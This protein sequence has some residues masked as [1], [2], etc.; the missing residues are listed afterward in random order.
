[1]IGSPEHF[2]QL[3]KSLARKL[4]IAA[5][6]SGLQVLRNDRGWRENEISIDYI[7]MVT[8]DHSYSGEGG[9]FAIK[10]KESKFREKV[11]PG[12]LVQ[13]IFTNKDEISQ[14][15]TETGTTDLRGIFDFNLFEGSQGITLDGVSYTIRISGQNIDT[16]ISL[17]NPNTDSWKKWEAEIWALGNR[18]ALASGNKEMINL[19]Q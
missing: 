11:N 7:W 10:Y 5:F 18:M 4:G 17:S 8:I 13:G 15:Y 1:M 6:Q 14:I 3:E 12:E 2:H 9:I 16:F 19:F